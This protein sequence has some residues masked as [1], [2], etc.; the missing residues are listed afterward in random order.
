MKGV[1]KRFLKGPFG[2]K[3][4]TEKKSRNAEKTERGALWSSP[5]LYVTQETFLAQFL[6]PTGTIWRLLKILVE[7]LG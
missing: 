2:E 7:L 6:G 5:V 4:F 1:L 3:S